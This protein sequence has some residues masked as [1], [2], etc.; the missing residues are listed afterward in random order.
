MRISNTIAAA[1]KEKAARQSPK[2]MIARILVLSGSP[3]VAMISPL[4]VDPY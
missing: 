3:G 1:L 4:G 2:Y